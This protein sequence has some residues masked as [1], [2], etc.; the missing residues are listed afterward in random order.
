MKTTLALATAAVLAVPAHAQSGPHKDAVAPSSPRAL[1]QDGITASNP[2]PEPLTRRQTTFDLLVHLPLRQAEALFGPEGERPWAG[3]RWD[4]Q[5]LY[6]Q[7]GHDTE[8]A[9]FTVQ[10]GHMNSVWVNTAFDLEGRRFQ[11]VYFL[12][13][14]LVTVID[15]RFDPTSADST[16]V[17]VIYTRT[18]ITAEGNQ[19]VD[20]M[21]A[22]DSKAGP[23]WQQAIDSYLASPKPAAN[24]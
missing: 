11:Y 12:P 20:K 15:V 4:P 23:E 19:H 2:T 10:H 9:V 16:A 13:G 17:H 5:F 3:P 6:P 24:P 14:I 8:G 7:P 21:A 18:A 1:R 22:A